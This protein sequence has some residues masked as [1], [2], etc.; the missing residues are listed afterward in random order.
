VGGGAGSFLARPPPPPPPAPDHETE[1]GVVPG[2][3]HVREEVTGVHGLR[4]VVVVA[5]AGQQDPLRVA[6]GLIGLCEQLRAL[7]GAHAHVADEH[8]EL[9]RGQRIERLLPGRDAH[10]VEVV[11]EDRGEDLAHV[12]FVVGIEN[13]RPPLGGA[14][15]ARGAGVGRERHAGTLPDEVRWAQASAVA[16]PDTGSLFTPAR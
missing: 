3:L 16:P 1:L 11:F 4:E 6:V 12:G 14:A 2:L 7:H 13:A 5:E 8:V 15:L 9:A 10:H